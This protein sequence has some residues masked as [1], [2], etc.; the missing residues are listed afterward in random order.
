MSRGREQGERPQGARDGTR[1]LCWA[2]GWAEARH[3]LVVG[4]VASGLRTVCSRP[5]K[6]I[7]ALGWASLT[8]GSAPRPV[9]V[10]LMWPQAAKSTPE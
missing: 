2:C 7:L 9:A 10:T 4:R 5:G 8:P 6:A 1:C 3:L